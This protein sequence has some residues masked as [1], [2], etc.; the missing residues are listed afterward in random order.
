MSYMGILGVIGLVVIVVVLLVWI[1]ATLHATRNPT[2]SGA[3]EKGTKRGD[4]TGGVVR[5]SAAQQNRR[6]EAHRI[7]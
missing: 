6:D 7:D 3:R 4:N 2:M 5:G 1:A